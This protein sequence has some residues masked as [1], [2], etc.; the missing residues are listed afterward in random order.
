DCNPR[1]KVT[2]T[3]KK[4]IQGNVTLTFYKSVSAWKVVLTFNKKVSK[5]KGWGATP[6]SKAGKRIKLKAKKWN[7]KQN[8]GNVLDIRVQYKYKGVIPN[9]KSI[10]LNGKELC[11]L[12]IL[13]TTPPQSTT[14]TTTT[15]ATTQPPTTA[16][17]SPPPT[18]AAPPSIRTASPHPPTTA[19]PSTTKPCVANGSKYNYAEVLRKSNLFYE[20]QRSGKLPPSQRVTWRKD[21]ALDDAIDSETGARLDLEG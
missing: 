20:A 19:A 12:S 11:G 7:K 4:T 18:T 3:R 9:L 17:P 5:F 21:S 1:F 10:K 16:V 2:K 14:T 6:S 15:T 8:K 13:L